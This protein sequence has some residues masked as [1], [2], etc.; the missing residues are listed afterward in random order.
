MMK[1]VVFAIVIKAIIDLIIDLVIRKLPIS[2]RAYI[3]G[4]IWYKINKSKTIQTAA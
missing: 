2:R 3:Y 1:G 4:L